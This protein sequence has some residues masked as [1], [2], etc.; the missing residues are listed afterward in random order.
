MF[1]MDNEFEPRMPQ[2]DARPDIGDIFAKARAK[3]GSPEPKSGLEPDQRCLGILTPGRMVMIV[4]APK[5][6]AVPPQLVEQAKQMVPSDRPLNILAI[7]FTELKPMMKDQLK[8][9]PYL[10]RL[11]SLAFIGH[12]VIVFEGHPSAFEAGLA[13]TDV[14]FIDSGMVPFLQPDWA[15]AAFRTMPPG[16]RIFELNRKNNGLMPVVRSKIA[17]GWR[18]GEPDG[19]RSYTNCLLVTL[20]KRPPIAVE[21]TT[22]QPLPDLATLAIAP[23]ELEWIAELPFKY[24]RLDAEKVIAITRQFAKLGEAT[25]GRLQAK[26]VT[27]GGKVETVTFDLK[28]EQDGHRLDLVRV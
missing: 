5:P 11:V 6:G 21:V 7:G 18:Y 14:L 2:V 23:D 1:G 4:P 8:C 19:E 24:D 3:V 27:A 17:P 16:S 20:A 25:S 15:E 9:L 28:L 22:G 12:N 10:A 26:L 13:G